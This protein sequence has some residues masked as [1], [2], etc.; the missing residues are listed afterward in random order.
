MIGD[1]RLNYL[2]LNCNLGNLGDRP[3]FSVGR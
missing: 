2:N 3:E 1:G